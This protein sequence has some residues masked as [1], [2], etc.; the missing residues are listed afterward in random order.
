[1]AHVVAHCRAAV[2]A[3]CVAPVV[4]HD[5]LS[6]QGA[7]SW[8]QHWVPL[9]THWYIGAQQFGLSPHM[10]HPSPPS[11]LAPVPPSFVDAAPS[12]GWP[13]S[14]AAIPSAP[15]P[16]VPSLGDAASGHVLKPHVRSPSTPHPADSAAR[17][18][19][20]KPTLRL[21]RTALIMTFMALQRNGA[22]PVN[23][24]WQA[25]RAPTPVAAC[26]SAQG[27]LV[28]RTRRG[29]DRD[30][31]DHGDRIVHVEGR[32]NPCLSARFPLA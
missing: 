22:S 1:M 29:Y 23:G 25:R 9:A 10:E 13:L 19:A 3:S 4:Q 8:P 31:S 32:K 17:A 26:L 30:R 18:T 21:R 6:P 27:R 12:P 5:P 24:S 7:P 20:N 14:M 11:P 2:H 28:C 16:G 15:I